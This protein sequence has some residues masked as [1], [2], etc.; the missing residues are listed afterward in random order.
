[1]PNTTSP[2]SSTPGY[3]QSTIESRNKAKTRQGTTSS[4][5][6][7]GNLSALKSPRLCEDGIDV[8]DI[9][10]KIT[11]KSERNRRYAAED[12]EDT[13]ADV[14]HRY[15]N[16]Q[17]FRGIIPT[18][19][20]GTSGRTLQRG[21]QR[22][23]LQPSTKAEFEIRR[24]K[25]TKRNLSP[26]G[27]YMLKDE[28]EYID[29]IRRLTEENKDL[30]KLKWDH[31][32]CETK[33]QEIYD[34]L[35]RCKEELGIYKTRCLGLEDN[36][37]KINKML[38]KEKQNSIA[39]EVNYEQERK[40]LKNKFEKELQRSSTY[41][42]KYKNELEVYKKIEEERKTTIRQ[43]NHL[44]EDK[45]KQLK[46]F[47]SKNRRL[48]NDL[49]RS[50]ANVLKYKEELEMYKKLEEERT[51]TIERLNHVV[52]DKEEELREI[53]SKYKRT[54]K[55]LNTY[56][57]SLDS[58]AEMEEQIKEHQSKFEKMSQIIE[59]F[60]VLYKES[61]EEKYKLED[62]FKRRV[63][64]LASVEET[65]RACLEIRDEQNRVIDD[66]SKNLSAYEKNY[67]LLHQE[68]DDL[69]V[70]LKEEKLKNQS[71]EM[72]TF[73]NKEKEVGFLQM[74]KEIAENK[75]QDADDTIKEL[76][77]NLEKKEKRLRSLTEQLL[78]S[79]EKVSKLSN[80]LKDC[81]NAK[82]EVVEESLQR[83][84][85]QNE[86]QKLVLVQAT[87]RAE[88][89]S[90]QSLSLQKYRDEA[91]RITNN[92]SKDLNEHVKKN[93]SLNKQVKQLLERN[94]T[95]LKEK[96]SAAIQI[97]KLTSILHD[98]EQEIQSLIGDRSRND[99][100][101]EHYSTLK[102][103]KEIL[104][105]SKENAETQIVEL[106]R[107]LHGTERKIESLTK[108]LIRLAET[109]EE[110]EKNLRKDVSSY[111]SAYDKMA[112]ENGDLS[113]QCSTLQRE[114]ASLL[115][116][117]E[118]GQIQIKDLKRTSQSM[119][120]KIESL[121]NELTS[122]RNSNEDLLSIHDKEK[123]LFE[124]DKKS[125][126]I[127][128]SE[129]K[130]AL[131]DKEKKI[132]SLN[133][134][135]RRSKEHVAM[136]SNDVQLIQESE[137]QAVSNSEKRFHTENASLQSEYE[138]A[139]LKNS[140]LTEQCL[141]LKEEKVNLMKDK[142]DG[143]RQIKE[144]RQ[145]SQSMERK[146]ETL[147]NELTSYQ[148]SNEDLLSIN[149]KERGLFEKDKKRAGKE[150][151]EL[152]RALQDKE[153]EIGSLND[154]LRKNGDLSEQCLTLKREKAH[155]IKDKEDAQL[156]IRT[157]RQTSQSME[158]EIGSLTHELTSYRNSNEDL[159]SIHDK[160]KGLLEKDKK[161][162]YIEINDLKRALHDKEKEFGSIND[163]LNRCKEHVAMLSNEVQLIQ[164]SREEAVSSSEKRFHK[165]KASLQSDYEKAILKI[166]DISK[167]CANL[168]K[169]K[170]STALLVEK[171]SKTV[172][173]RETKIHS[174]EAEISRL[175][176]SL[177][178]DV[179]QDGSYFKKFIK[180]LCFFDF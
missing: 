117:K 24:E 145:T 107:T 32:K 57:T 134:E 106:T 118:D 103:E 91:E 78:R 124:K 76:Y 67:K 161:R 83:L 55:L 50:N 153:K 71:K 59:K 160:E 35:N 94:A 88:D 98:K 140:D 123:G 142:E 31:K 122:Y 56:K 127:E 25:A 131:H 101:S 42:M 48:Q 129:L 146:I 74:E 114:K 151:S 6:V 1:M 147:I 46:E 52:N 62:E 116:D 176:V 15:N 17:S 141:A 172:E 155:L 96:E 177:I 20:T 30:K 137:E 169:D 99:N 45:E 148:N 143:Q 19:P 18:P 93:E 128:I 136:L 40:L 16:T 73:Q 119:E 79:E 132:E 77:R 149:D 11:T 36:N 110:T 44:V 4:G 154:E 38:E 29:Q 178:K 22:R 33:Q 27:E 5:K 66:L 179:T 41:V 108:D 86:N 84:Q 70:R 175:V 171:L 61:I 81:H 37:Q 100:L 8:H 164:K 13:D 9:E 85:I 2:A 89:L 26:R 135:L 7:K 47:E 43:L 162:A 163:E 138:K 156:E 158:R 144:L 102:K 173:D 139:I 125:A 180:R 104:V 165:E 68:F 115:K 133:D 54:L 87:K 121:T 60:K 21:R 51:T 126:G 58:N 168:H 34:T 170:K 150:I 152:K 120:R 10:I 112:R 92:L 130:R 159:L 75:L 39:S 65:H 80:E 90:E 72:S 166:N 97:N 105:K 64:D 95:I 12:Y 63:D 111:R 28:Q 113:E 157:L 23:L 109:S 82:N 69:N 49:P 14:Q 174:L 3:L 53:G 167:E